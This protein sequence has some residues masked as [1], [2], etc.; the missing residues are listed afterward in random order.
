MLTSVG[1]P[2]WLEHLLHFVFFSKH[3]FHS[4]KIIFLVLPHYSSKI[5]QQ[6]GRKS[7]EESKYDKNY[8]CVTQWHSKS[9]QPLSWS[10]F[11]LPKFYSIQCEY[12]LHSQLV[13]TTYKADNSDHGYSNLVLKIRVIQQSFVGWSGKKRLKTIYMRK[14]YVDHTK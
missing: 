5:K 7:L 2:A 9:D 3:V 8:A 14:N 4:Y 6:K 1:F 10:E 13:L 11:N 12:R